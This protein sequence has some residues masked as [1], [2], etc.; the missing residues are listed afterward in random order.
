[1]A[2]SFFATFKGELIDRVRWPTRRGVRQA[3]FEWLEV[4]YN[5]QRRHSALGYLS[6]VAFEARHYQAAA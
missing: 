3:I 6:P 2:E 5:R 1:M 4:F